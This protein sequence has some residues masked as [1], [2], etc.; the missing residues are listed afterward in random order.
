[1]DL[2]RIRQLA[3]NILELCE[4]Y[5]PAEYQAGLTLVTA[6]CFDGRDT[7]RASPVKI[8]GAASARRPRFTDHAL[9]HMRPAPASLARL[10]RRAFQPGRVTRSWSRRGHYQSQNASAE[11][12][13][14]RSIGYVRPKVS[15]RLRRSA[16]DRGL[17]RK[18]R[19]TRVR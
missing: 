17:A 12:A 2:R 4:G 3:R 1:M 5:E 10:A 19:H 8:A 16:G 18:A 6:G 13:Y 9:A 15:E 11:M 7:P 14:N